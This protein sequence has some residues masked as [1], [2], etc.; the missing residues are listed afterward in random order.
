MWFLKQDILFALP[1]EV[2]RPDEPSFNGVVAHMPTETQ[3]FRNMHEV[4]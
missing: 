1:I 2:T 4:D 3:A